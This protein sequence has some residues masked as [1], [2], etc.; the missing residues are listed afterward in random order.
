MGRPERAAR[1]LYGVGDAVSRGGCE[2]TV[3]DGGS[4]DVDR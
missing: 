2:L 3:G 1:L 4:E